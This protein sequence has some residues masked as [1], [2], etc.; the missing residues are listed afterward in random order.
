MFFLKGLKVCSLLY[1]PPF[2]SPLPSASPLLSRLLAFGVFPS[3]RK[4]LTLSIMRSLPAQS[5]LRCQISPK[6]QTYVGHSSA[7]NVRPSVRPSFVFP[8]C[9]VISSVSFPACWFFSI[10]LKTPHLSLTPIKGKPAF[11]PKNLAIDRFYTPC[12]PLPFPFSSCDRSCSYFNSSSQTVLGS[13]ILR[14]R[15]CTDIVF[16]GLFFFP[17]W[18]QASLFGLS[19]Y[20]LCNSHVAEEPANVSFRTPGSSL[21]IKCTLFSP[22]NVSVLLIASRFSPSLPPPIPYPTPGD[23]HNISEYLSASTKGKDATWG[24][25]AHSRLRGKGKGFSYEQ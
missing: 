19:S 21:R 6:G 10:Y 17:S 1:L 14:E 12:R 23:I 5:P 16:A 11:P 24:P 20:P 8:K 7:P 9:I 2:P 4:F 25:F 3:C 13:V 22:L 15:I 18:P